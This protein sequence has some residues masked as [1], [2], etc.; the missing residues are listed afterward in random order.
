M[1]VSVANAPCSY[2]AFEITVGVDPNVPGPLEI[3]D[4]IKTAGYD[5]TDLGPLGFLGV[6]RQLAHRLAARNLAL[7][8]GYLALPFSRPELMPAAIRELEHLLDAFDAVSAELHGGEPPRPTLADAGSDERRSTPGRARRERRLG[9]SRDAWKRLAEGVKR[10]VDRCL[11]RGYE[12]AF[13]HHAASYVEAPWEIEELLERTEVCL[14]LDTGHL[15][16]G[17]GDPVQALKDWGARI[18][19]MHLKDV[20]LAVVEGIIREGAPV[21]EIWRR[22]A[23]CPLGEGDVD[24]DAVLAELRERGYSGWIVVE[25]DRIPSPLG[26]MDEVRREQAA[27]REFLRTRGL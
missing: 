23:F 27:N 25:Q 4:A 3:L 2:G 8:G 17:G 26:S 19:H 18:N 1:R 22:A 10:A 21:E 24:I 14:A 5:G 16:L 12:P 15:L 20:R 7:A 13:H 11:A 9:L 6:G